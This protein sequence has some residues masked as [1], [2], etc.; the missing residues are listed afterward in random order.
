MRV[1]CQ[2]GLMGE[3]RRLRVDYSDFEQFEAYSEIYNL[4]ARL[5]FESAQD[6]WEANP[7]IESSVKPEDFRMVRS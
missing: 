5:G 6:A 3:R 7:V 2:S 1:K 4:A